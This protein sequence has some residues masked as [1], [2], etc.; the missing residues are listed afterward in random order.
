MQEDLLI[1]SKRERKRKVI[2]EDVIKGRIS[3]KDAAPHLG[4]GYR[5]AKRQL[6]KYRNLGDAGLVHGNRGKAPKCSHKLDFKEKILLLYNKEYSGFGPTFAAEKLLERDNLSIN[7]ETLR[8]W[9]LEEG[10]WKR[11][12]KHKEYRK[13]RDARERFGELLQ[14][15]GSDH[16]WF[17]KDKERACLLNI[18]DDATSKT[19]SQLATGETTE[20]LL[21]TFRWWIERYGVPKAVYVDFKNIY[22]SP[23]RSQ[24][25]EQVKL[26]NT[27]ERVCALLDVE[28]IGARS[29]QAKGRVERNH[30]VYQDRFVK[31]LQLREIKTIMEANKYLREDYL[32]KI[33]KRFEKP[34]ASKED[35]HCTVKAYG[36]LEQIFCWVY[37]RQVQQD[38]TFQFKNQ[39]YQIEMPR[40]KGVK[41]KDEI[42]IR[43]HLD[44]SMSYWHDETRLSVKTLQERPKCAQE[45]SKKEASKSTE[46]KQK[47]DEKTPW[48]K[49]NPNWIKPKKKVSPQQQQA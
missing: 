15:D 22:I 1:M 29:P 25:G 14:I 11:C 10:S 49:F 4:V 26:M 42:E 23:G 31:E 30:G 2:L 20:V 6:S 24:N 8:L 39:S 37:K 9:L 47:R 27:F 19:L 38:W 48:R 32:D 45:A 36:N 46:S 43:K 13:R 12:R 44:G 17:G 7:R 33:N 18:V 40:R 5:Q 34:A 35:A 28:I 3:L 16:H 21:K 41:P